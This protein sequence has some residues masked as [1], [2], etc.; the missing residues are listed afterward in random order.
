M[1]DSFTIIGNSKKEAYE[2]NEIKLKLLRNKNQ[3]KFKF[4]SLLITESFVFDRHWK[5][6]NQLDGNKSQ[7]WNICQD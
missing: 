6:L 4:D 5:N 2:I 3:I 1:W 7:P